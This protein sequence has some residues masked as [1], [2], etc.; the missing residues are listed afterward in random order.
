V[1]YDNMLPNTTIRTYDRYKVNLKTMADVVYSYGTAVA[2]A[3]WQEKTLIVPVYHS[4]TTSRHIYYIAGEWNLKVVK[5]YGCGL[6][7]K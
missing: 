4:V 7:V 3:D 1:K 2:Y 6:H 5:L